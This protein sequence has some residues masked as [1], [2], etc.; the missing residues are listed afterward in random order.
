MIRIKGVRES[1]NEI[2]TILQDC[3]A[4]A[5]RFDQRN[6]VAGTRVRAALLKVKNEAHG[7]RLLIIGIRGKRLAAARKK[8]FGRS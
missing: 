7:T 8:E 2:L 3:L 6:D 1:V 5:D 4:D